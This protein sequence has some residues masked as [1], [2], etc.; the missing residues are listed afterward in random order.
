MR[1]QEGRAAARKYG[2]ARGR[3][4]RVAVALVARSSF[5]ALTEH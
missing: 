2:V 1:W 5:S 4:M 3:R